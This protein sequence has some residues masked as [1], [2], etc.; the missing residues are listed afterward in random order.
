[1]KKNKKQKTQNFSFDEEI[2]RTNIA[3]LIDSLRTHSRIYVM[4]MGMHLP[5]SV[6]SEKISTFAQRFVEKE[7]KDGYDAAYIVARDDNTN[8]NTNYQMGLILDGTKTKNA[9]AH[10]DNANKILQDVIGPEYSADGMIE[11]SNPGIVVNAQDIAKEK[12]ADYDE[13]YRQLSL[14][15]KDNPTA[16][17]KGKAFFY[18]KMKK[19]SF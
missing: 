3:L 4:K 12:F 6:D 11:K 14:L 1:M 8:G 16:K 9:S 19:D 10:I 7:K 17:E 13:A 15:A 5:Q 18:S 2:L